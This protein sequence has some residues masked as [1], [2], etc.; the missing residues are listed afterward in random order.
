MIK[1]ELSEVEAS[2]LGLVWHDGP[3]TPYAIRKVFLG[4]PNPTWS[5]SAGT[6]YPLIERLII[7][8]LIRSTPCSTGKRQGHKISLTEPGKRALQKWLAIPIPDWVAGI[9]PD[10]LRTRIRFLGALDPKGQRAFVN[11]AIHQAEVHLWAVQADCER[12]QPIGGFPFLM[13]RGTLLS[14]QSRCAFLA[15]VAAAMR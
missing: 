15:E 10:P 8:K 1:R 11:A 4:S 13:A 14:M 6:I 5:G 2:V 9:P 3:S 12:R 7:R